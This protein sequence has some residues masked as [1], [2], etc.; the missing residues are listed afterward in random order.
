[1]RLARKKLCG[2]A[3]NAPKR[4]K[5]RRPRCCTMPPEIRRF[6]RGPQTIVQSVSAR[7]RTLR[8]K[9]RAGTCGRPGRRSCRWCS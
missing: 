3:P 7:L 1:V 4:M 9:W 6:A 8:E 2:A 5:S